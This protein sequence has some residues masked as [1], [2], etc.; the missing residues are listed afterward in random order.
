MTH[1][2]SPGQGVFYLKP[3][4]LGAQDVRGTSAL[5]GPER[6]EDR[7]RRQATDEA[8]HTR[9]WLSCPVYHLFAKHDNSIFTLTSKLYCKKYT[10]KSRETIKFLNI[11]LKFYK[12]LFDLLLTIQYN[13]RVK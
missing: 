6:S 12:N 11:F 7:C 9:R 13:F 1:P 5:R 3:S 8:P 2:L 4:P 10:T